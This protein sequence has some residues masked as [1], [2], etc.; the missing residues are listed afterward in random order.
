MENDNIN[1]IFN[2]ALTLHQNGNL[3]E[4]KF[5]LEKIL[6][7]LPKHL[8]SI[9]LLGTL[10][11][12]I[13]EYQTAIELLTKSIK[14]KP[15]FIE[16]HNNL[17]NVFQELGRNKEAVSCYQRA[18]KLNPEYVEAQYN[19]GKVFQELGK[20]KQA[21][22]V[23]QKAIQIDFK[24]IKAHNNLGNV[25]QELG[26]NKEAVSCYQRAIKLNP[27]YAE[28]HNNLG[29]VFQELGR[30]KEAVSCYQR[31]IKLNPEYAEA[32]YNLGFVYQELGRN[33]EAVSCYQRAIKLNPEYA[34]AHYNL[35]TAYQELGKYQ[36]AMSVY[37]KAIQIDFKYIKA[38]NNLGLV[39]QELGKY[40]EAVSCYQRAIKLNPEYAEALNNI[41]RV[42]LAIGDFE[43]GWIGHEFR[44]N[45]I[46]EVYELL[47]IKDKKIWNGKKFDGTLVVHGEQG[48]GDEILYSSMFPDLVNYHD[49]LIITTDSRLIPIMQR[50]FPKVN[51]I[52]RYNNNLSNKNNSSTHILAGSLGR[53]FRNS[54]TDFK[55]DKQQWLVPSPKKC[56]NFKK[57]LSNLNKYKVGISWRSSGLKSSERSISLTQFASI[58]PKHNFEIINLEYGDIHFEKNMLE[59]KKKRKLIYFDDL[60]YKNDLEGLAALIKN[61]DLVVSVANATAHLSGAIGMQT[62]V[63]VPAEPQWYWYSENKESIWYPN[64]QLFRKKIKEE[65][66]DVLNMIKEEILLKYKNN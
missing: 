66:A 47:G 23:Y 32:H 3:N 55:K 43:N 24:Y 17:G 53:I 63:M 40:Q 61:C 51:F 1:K 58:F 8:P 39:Y 38:H 62:L 2:S 10:S 21:M 64:T 4:A 57:S 31:A 18:I 65:W 25:F 56:D 30:N 28:A 11:A 20:N 15:E 44:N 41:G 46:K 16:A 12:Q 54:L 27:E 5:L 48:I 35:G 45:G 50:S 52:N 49:N 26:R 13:Q 7:S 36:K 42:Q 59:K 60:D 6:T 22:S 14:I 37:Q 19:L 33:K 34:E 9:F 29:N